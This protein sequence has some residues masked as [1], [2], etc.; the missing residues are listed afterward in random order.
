MLKYLNVGKLESSSQICFFCL[1]FFQKDHSGC[2]VQNRLETIQTRFKETSDLFI[3]NGRTICVKCTCVRQSPYKAR[4]LPRASRPAP[5]QRHT[6][7]LK[8]PRSQAHTL[9]QTYMSIVNAGCPVRGRLPSSWC[10]TS[11]PSLLYFTLRLQRLFSGLMFLPWSV[12]LVF[13]LCS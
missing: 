2:S 5:R 7:L 8:R 13:L 3:W 11:A 1:F 10:V 4:T 6:D 12:R 9:T